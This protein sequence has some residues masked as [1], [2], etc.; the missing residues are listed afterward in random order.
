[1]DAKKLLE[2]KQERATLVNQMRSLIGE[3]ESKEMPAEKREELTKM[4]TR[5]DTLNG[6]VETEERQLERERKTGEQQEER[7]GKASRRRDQSNVLSGADGEN[8]VMLKN[9]AI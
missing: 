3:Y 1:M 5:F 2:A 9:I 6:T 7:R 8:K 4:E